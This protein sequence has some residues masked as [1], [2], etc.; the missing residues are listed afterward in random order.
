VIDEAAVA[1][2]YERYGHA[3]YR[4]CE[5]LCGNEAEAREL[6][7]ET[8]CQFF[9]NRGRFEGRAKPFTYLY[10]IAT[11][12]S[13]DRLRRRAVAGVGVSFDETRD[14][15]SPS[16]ASGTQAAQELAVLTEGLDD[17]ALTVAVMIHVDGLTQDEI[18]V[19]L[20]L[21]RRTIGKRLARFLAHTR[22]RAGVANVSRRRPPGPKTATGGRDD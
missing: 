12:L 8:F 3:L 6:V 5:R 15:E 20:D 16:P 22:A 17:E 10:R 9:N 14:G 4:R 21:S 1:E 13:I 18:A 2:L 19:A 11:N 7:Q